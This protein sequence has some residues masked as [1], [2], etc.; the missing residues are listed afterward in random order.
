M[1]TLQ[2]TPVPTPLRVDEGG[3]VRVGQTRVTLDTLVGS[4]RDGSTA[5]EIV[6]QYPTLALADVHAALAYYLTHR[7]EVEAYLRGREAE[8]AEL[9]REVEQ[10]SDQRGVRERLLARQTSSKTGGK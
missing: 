9:R 7:P 5:E 3:A 8:A 2:L 1:A 4:Y 10:I 6:Q